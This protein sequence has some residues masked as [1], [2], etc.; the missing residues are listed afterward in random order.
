[1]KCP[2]CGMGLIKLS[3]K[4]LRW[5]NAP[6]VMEFGSMQ[7]SWSLCLISKRKDLISFL[8]SSRNS[9]ESVGIPGRKMFPGVLESLTVP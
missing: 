6:N 8:V 1:M 9:Q 4:E 3:T 2:K 7:A 5:I